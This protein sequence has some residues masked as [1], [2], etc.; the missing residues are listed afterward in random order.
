MMVAQSH[1]LVPV[2]VKS[3]VFDMKSQW[4]FLMDL[5]WGVRAELRIIPMFWPKKGTANN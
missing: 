4:D 3:V 1:I 2:M 5:T